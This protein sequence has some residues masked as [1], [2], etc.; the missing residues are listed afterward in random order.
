MC[1]VY[2]QCKCWDMRGFFNL[3]F[4]LQ[5]VRI[6]FISNNANIIRILG[7]GVRVISFMQF[8]IYTTFSA[9]YK[10]NKKGKICL[11]TLTEHSPY[12]VLF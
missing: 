4:F 1:P 6:E 7:D 11:T 5:I 3:I 10:L 8:L 2:E 9:F 12:C